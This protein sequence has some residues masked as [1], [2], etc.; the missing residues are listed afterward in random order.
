MG[1]GCMPPQPTSQTYLPPRK[2]LLHYFDTTTATV[3]SGHQMTSDKG[4]I[5]ATN[6]S[7][8]RAAPSL[9]QSKQT[10]KYKF[11]PDSL[12]KILEQS[13]QRLRTSTGWDAFVLQTRGAPHIRD[14]VHTV[15]HP[16][17]TMM[18]RI[19]DHGAPVE[20][21]TMPWDRSKIE[22]RLRRGSH[23][24]VDEHVDFVRD[25][26][27]DFAKKGF[28]AVLPYDEVKH[29]PNLRLSP[30]HQRRDLTDLV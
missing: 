24:S 11:A 19:R 13:V 30:L 27:A 21:T 23:K 7:S 1:L 29:L 16:A 4:E 10:K 9:H 3:G 20:T 12:G 14:D 18:K 8:K 22:E 15:P 5:Q 25:E 26:M 6:W 2:S 17:A 28:W